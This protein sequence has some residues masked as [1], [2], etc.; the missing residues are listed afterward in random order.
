MKKLLHVVA[1]PR[2]EKSRSIKVAKAFLERFREVHP[3]WLVDEINV[4]DETLPHLTAHATFVTTVCA[5]REKKK[6]LTPL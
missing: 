1:S 4:F 6:E 2:G 3:E 5:Y